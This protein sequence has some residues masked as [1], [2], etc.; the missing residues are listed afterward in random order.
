MYKNFK[1]ALPP[2]TRLSDNKIFPDVDNLPNIEQFVVETEYITKQYADLQIKEALDNTNKMKTS[3]EDHISKIKQHYFDILQAN[4]K[5]DRDYLF[6]INKNH[7]SNIADLGNQ[8]IKQ[9]ELLSK[10]KSIYTEK[11]SE[12]VDE[13]EQ[14]AEEVGKIQISIDEM[15]RASSELESDNEYTKKKL[16]Q[17]D[18]EANEILQTTVK[19]LQESLET[20]DF[21]Q[22]EI[23]SKM[24]SFKWD[25]LMTKIVKLIQSF[26]I[27]LVSDDTQTHFSS[28]S[29]HSSKVALNSPLKNSTQNDDEILLFDEILINRNENEKVDFSESFEKVLE[30][31]KIKENIVKFLSLDNLSTSQVAENCIKVFEDYIMCSEML[32][33]YKYNKAQLVQLELLGESQRVKFMM[34][35]Q[36]KNETDEKVD[37]YNTSK[38]KLNKVLT[39]IFNYLPNYFINSWRHLKLAENQNLEVKYVTPDPILKNEPNEKTSIKKRKREKKTKKQKMTTIR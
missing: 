32:I 34:M 25:Q 30:N 8:V 36:M 13:L 18:G 39:E 4:R 27:F 29:S 3:F 35:N 31:L 12:F 23:E 10:V 2:H 26:E 19:V 17:M 9:K 1:M 28:L 6:K 11:K 24:P 37:Y 15:K 38:I 7:E 20:L 22:R 16:I 21:G 14:F 5:A 33:K